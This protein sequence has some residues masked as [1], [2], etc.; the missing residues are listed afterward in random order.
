MVL[1]P[2]RRKA[3]P[4]RETSPR[5]AK[6]NE[7][8]LQ[9]SMDPLLFD[10]INRIYRLVALINTDFKPELC[11]RVVQMVLAIHQWLLSRHLSNALRFFAVFCGTT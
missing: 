4:L 1:T 2:L 5:Y 9:Q 10:R 8:C 11:N 7:S 3:T 6:E